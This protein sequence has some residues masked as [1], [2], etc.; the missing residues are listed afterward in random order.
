MSSM[1]F[2]SAAAALALA[3]PMILPTSTFAQRGPAGGGGGGGGAVHAGGS[4]GGGGGSVGGGSF[5]GRG[6]G[7]FAAG[8]A[9]SVTAGRMGAV[10]AGPSF[11]GRGGAVTA[12]TYGT[13]GGRYAGGYYRHRHDGFW[14][15]FA[16]GALG[17][18]AYYGYGPDYY[19]P[20]YYDDDY[21]YDSGVAVAPGGDAVTYCMQRYRSYDPASGTYLGYD[22]LRHPCP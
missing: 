9:P 18:Y 13:Y 17:S 20:Y 6:S 3:L 15:G 12:P 14:P 22:G 11:A 1:K 8:P 16:I 2:L 21:Y 5:A 7:G 4:V 19:D 10:G